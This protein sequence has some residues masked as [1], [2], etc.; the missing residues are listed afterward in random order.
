V[1][2]DAAEARVVDDLIG[3]APQTRGPLLVGDMGEGAYRAA[4]RE[5]EAALAALPAT[6]DTIVVHTGDPLA[7]YAGVMERLDDAS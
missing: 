3:A 1:P 5:T 6:D 4:G 2:A 7:W